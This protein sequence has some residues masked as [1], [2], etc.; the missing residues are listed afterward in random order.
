MKKARAF[1]KKKTVKGGAGI[2]KK[3]VYGEQKTETG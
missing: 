3:A 2:K 1:R